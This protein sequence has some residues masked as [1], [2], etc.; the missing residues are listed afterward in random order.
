MNA[1]LYTDRILAALATKNSDIIIDI[2][3]KSNEY[4]TT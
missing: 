4:L 1:G 3:I 2:T